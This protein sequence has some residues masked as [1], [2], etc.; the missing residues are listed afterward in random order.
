MTTSP[1]AFSSSAFATGRP[2]II[3]GGQ[4]RSLVPMTDAI[5]ASRR[6]FAAAANG[7]L[8]GPLRSA[9]SRHRVLVMPTE[10]SSGSA[11]VK[12]ISLQP[13]GW[14]EGLPSIGGG[15]LWIDG[16]TGRITAMLDAAAL[17]A[18]RTGAASG[19]ATALLA[20]PASSILAMLGSGGQAAD[21]VG[22]VCAVRPIREVRVFSRRAQR[23]EQL[24]VRLAD[25]H[26]G[27]SFLP[28]ASAADAVRGA[29]VICTATR[30]QTPLFEVSDLAPQV[31]INAV[32]SYRADMCEVPPAA[33][34]QAAAV[35]IDQLEAALEEA[36]D[37]I[38]AIEAG[39]LRQEDLVEI[40]RLLA[41]PA[42]PPGGLTIFKSVG[43]A[44][45]DWALAELVVARA[46]A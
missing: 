6:A 16:A 43:I 42:R 21:Q 34:A 33:F 9:L 37:I 39:Q 44:A 12:V 25:A 8:S 28:A 15:V 7:E 40:G 11:L 27:V 17:T 36:G 2:V 14:E 24:C 30:S 1:P 38:Q 29:H 46:R 19:L 32:G 3:D 4:L 35:V 13:D 23:R 41:S 22:A 5:E 10:H 45:Q 18:L 31:H 20:A 26:P